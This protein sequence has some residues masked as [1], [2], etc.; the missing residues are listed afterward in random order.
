P[1]LL[2]PL[3]QVAFAVEE[4]DGD[5]RE[6]EVGGALQVIAGEDAEA[7]R[8]DRQRL[9]DPELGAE[10]RDRPA[11]AREGISDGSRLSRQRARLAEGPLARLDRALEALHVAGPER[12]RRDALRSEVAEERRGVAADDLPEVGV[13]LGEELARLGLPGPREVVREPAEP[14]DHLGPV[15]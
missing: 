7:A 15:V 1:V 6:A 14:R 8:V 9:V 2:E 10:V 13:E 11:R 12:G 3:A 4:A 5:E